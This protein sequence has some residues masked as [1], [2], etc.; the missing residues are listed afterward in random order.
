MK[1]LTG[2]S[3]GNVENHFSSPEGSKRDNVEEALKKMKPYAI[4]LSSGVETDGVKDKE[5]ILQIIRRV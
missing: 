1:P 3:Y 5:K 2:I 4:D